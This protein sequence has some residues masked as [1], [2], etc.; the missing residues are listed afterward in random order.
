[1]SLQP[2]PNWSGWLHHFGYSHADPFNRPMPIPEMGIF[3][4]PDVTICFN[5]KWSPLLV[6]A[7]SRL[8]YPELY[9]VDSEHDGIWAD[10]QATK[11]IGVIA[12][13]ENP[14]LPQSIQSTECAYYPSWYAGIEY[15]PH[16][17]FNPSEGFD[18]QYPVA[19][20]FRFAAI[21]T[22]F[23]DW[24]DDIFQGIIENTTG[25][26]ENDVFVSFLSLPT[27]QNPFDGLDY[28]TIKLTVTGTGTVKLK[29]LL[30]PFGGRALISFDPV[31]VF[32][33]F[34]AIWS[35]DDRIIELNRDIVS[36]VP[37]TDLDAI[38]EI[39]LTEDKTH[40]IY[41]TF[42]PTINDEAP[43]FQF[44]GGFRGYELCGDLTVVNPVTGDPIDFQNQSE[45]IYQEGIIVATYDDLLKA[46]NEHKT[47]EANRWLLASESSNIIS[48]IEVDP[49]TGT[50]TVKQSGGG[51]GEAIEALAQEVHY[52]GATNQAI[53]FK[54]LL[55]ELNANITSGYSVLTLVNLSRIITNPL[56][57]VAWSDL[58]TE[59]NTA[60]PQ[61]TIDATEL[62][63]N[64]FCAD[65]YEGVLNYAIAEHSASEAELNFIVQFAQEIPPSTWSQWY[66]AG[67]TTPKLGFESA[68][69]YQQPSITG[70][71]DYS[72][73]SASVFKIFAQNTLANRK[74]RLATSGK[75]TDAT[76]RDYDGVFLRDGTV[77]TR[78]HVRLGKD[79]VGAA[80]S[81]N[82]P[83]YQDLSKYGLEYQPAYAP[84]MVQFTQVFTP[85]SGTI[86]FKLYDL[87]AQ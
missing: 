65:S 8:R 59:Y 66:E 71:I 44:G 67:K 72:E 55:D 77:F 79:L 35:P 18:P 11:L 31:G 13:A 54:K 28:P 61:V 4:S 41:I 9:I 81:T 85:V 27:Y 29:F 76:G 10:Q 47:I 56:D 78:N 5:S 60:D 36:L 20:F 58:V 45:N 46:L 21:D 74:W 68:P 86:T 34:Q 69:C 40:E 3:D 73:Y 62:A 57:V 38:E 19:P 24:I 83:L 42:L 2:L 75:L 48:G 37:E 16:N 82:N 6:G 14:C 23:P 51:Q 64:L 50:V 17:P 70:S 49:D 39:F 26:L 87:G 15:I 7:L 30:V 1:M 25:Y 80:N 12:G 33:I 63:Q 84:D 32:D 22:W 43:I 52:G 53:Q